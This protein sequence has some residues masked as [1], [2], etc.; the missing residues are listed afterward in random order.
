[1]HPTIQE[2]GDIA[3]QA[4]IRR[5]RVRATDAITRLNSKGLTAPTTGHPYQF[6]CRGI[7][8]GYSKAWRDFNAIGNHATAQNIA[9]WLADDNGELVHLRY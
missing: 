2:L 4:A 5:V 1:M 6:G 7:F 8:G 3:D 9:D